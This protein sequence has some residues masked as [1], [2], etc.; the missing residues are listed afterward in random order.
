MV[1]NLN[2]PPKFYSKNWPRK[3]PTNLWGFFMFP[4]FIFFLLSAFCCLCFSSLP[5]H[6]DILNSKIV[7]TRWGLWHIYIYVLHLCLGYCLRAS[8]SVA[9]PTITYCIT[10]SLGQL[11]ASR[12]L[13][14]LL[15]G[16][17]SIESVPTTPD[18]NT[19]AKASRYKWEAYRDTNW[20]CIYHFLPKRGRT[21]AKISR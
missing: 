13:H 2:F 11:L 14:A 4:S 9:C 20:W 17:K 8:R 18:T 12:I 10:D 15:V 21:F 7:P 19:S 1:K 6:F 3:T 5:L 16:E